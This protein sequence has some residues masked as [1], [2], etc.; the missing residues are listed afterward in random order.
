MGNFIARA[1]EHLKQ[2]GL[3]AQR[4][5][6]RQDESI[7]KIK[8]EGA[9]VLQQAQDGGF[10]TAS[11]S[12]L[13]EAIKKL[14]AYQALINDPNGAG[15]ETF[16]AT[17]EQIDGLTAKLN[18]L[19]GVAEK[20]TGTFASADEVMT[21]W[22]EH[23]NAG[24]TASEGM[25]QTLDEKLA[26]ATSSWDARI[27][28]QT[29]YLEDC[30]KSLDEYEQELQELSDKLKVLEQKH[31]NH[32]WLWKKTHARQYQREEENIEWLR[33]ETG[34]GHSFDEEGNIKRTT[35]KGLVDDMRNY[36]QDAQK[37]LALLKQLKAEELGLTESEVQA[38]EKKADAKRLTNEQMQEG[39]KLLEEEYARTEHTTEEGIKKREQL[40]EAIDQMNQELKESTGEWMKLADAEKLAE[41]AGKDTFLNKEGKGFIASP[42]EIQKAT[43][44]LERRRDALIKNMKTSGEATKEQERELADLTKK[45]KDLKFEQDN[46]NM[47][48]EKMQM[49]MRTP[50]NAV[51]LDEL[52]AAIKRADAELKRME[53]S[54]GQN[55]AQYQEF[56]AQVKNTKNMLKEMEGQAKAS[57]TAWEKAWSRLKT[58]VVMYMGF[59]AVWQKMVGTADDIMELSDKMGE[60]RKTTGFTA[61]EV[62][63][64]S[65]N[66]KRLDVRTPLTQLMELSAKA[67]QL[68]LKTEQDV[69]GFTE[70]ANKLMIALPEMGAEA[71]TEM[72]KVAIAT[73]EV[74]KIQ[75]Q[76]NQ[77]LIEGSSA[78]EV[79]LSKVGSTID[80]L[81]AN[82]AAAAPQITDFVKRVGAVGAQSGITIDQIAALGATVD[83]IG[84][85]VEMSATAL[86]RMIPAIKNNAFEV[87]KA[88]GM[89]PNALREMFDEAGGGMEAMLAIF[90][91][92]K[93]AGMD[94]DSIEKML[95]MGGMQDVMKQLNQQGVRAGIVFAGLSQNVDELRKNLGVATEAYEDNI[96][97]LQEYNKMNDTTAAKWERFKNQL[98]EFFVGD[99]TQGVLGAIIDFLRLGLDF[100]T[101]NNGWSAA[102]RTIGV[103]LLAVKLNIASIF[104]G[105]KNISVSLKGIAMTIGLI[106]KE[107]KK[108]AWGNIFTAMA[109]A[110]LWLWR[111]LAKL[112]TAT[113]RANESLGKTKE[114][115][116]QVTERFDG[117]WD[118][119]K[120]TSEALEEAKASH[121][122]LSDAVD[123][124]RKTTDGSAESSAKLK[125]AE[126]ELKNSEN[127]VTRASNAH[128]AA[129]SQMNSIYGKYLGFILTEAN[130]S[131]LAAA[132]HD[133]V[134]AA[135]EREMLMKQK[136]AAIGEVDSSYADKIAEG[137]GDLNE[138]LV[139]YGHLQRSEAAKAMSDMQ[140][141]MRENL[142]YDETKGETVVNEAIIKQLKK[143]HSGLDLSDAEAN[144]IAGLW[145]NDYLKENFKMGES[146]R[147]GL[148]G[149][150]FSKDDTGGWGNVR[151]WGSNLR[152]D[153]AET[154]ADREKGRGATA[155][156]YDT[157]LTAARTKEA[158]NSTE[159]LNKLEKRAND[160]KKKIL[161]KK[162]SD[163]DRNEAY[164]ELANSLEGL[165]NRI[166]ELDPQKDAATIDRLNNL[167]TSLKGQGIDIKKLKQAREKIHQT[168][169]EKATFNEGD[170]QNLDTTNPWGEK[171]GA[172]S[173]DWK[174][175]TA[176]Q[177]VNR[178]K[179]MKD[180]V[181]AIQTDSDV[182]TVLAEDAALKKAIEKG[183]A[184]DMRTVIEWYNTERLK[185]QD[186]LHARY[187]TNTG[188]WMD[189]KKV[190][191]RKKMLHD[192]TRMFLDELDAYYTER[193][194]K[195]Q[196]AG[197]EE[198]ITEAEM[199]NRTLA[200]EAE[201]RQRRMELQKMYGDKAEEVTQ[202]EQNAIFNIIAE[203]TD[204]DVKVIKGLYQKTLD[205]V[206]KVSK[207]GEQGEK[208]AREFR[209]KMDKQAM[210]DLLKEQNA[211][212][213][214]MKAIQDIIDKERPF[215]GITKNLRE[216]LVTMGILTADMTEERNRLMAE[217]ADMAD[218]NAR[219]AAEELKRTAFMLGEAEN[220]Y[221]TTIEDIMKRMADAGMTAWADELKANPK[222]REAL[223]AQLHQ[224]YDDIQEAIKKEASLMKKHAENMWNNILLPGGDG[225]T[226]VK[227]AFEQA[228]SQLGIDQ[229]RV[230]RANSLIGAGAA[231]ERVADR[232]AIKQMKLQLTMQEHYFNLMRKQGQQRID[233]LKRQADELERQGELEKASRVRQDKAHAEMSLRLATTKEQTE[234]LKQQEDI[235]A[236]T[237]E[238]QNRLYKELREWGDLLANS[239]RDLMEASNAGNAEYYNEL[240]KLN[241]TGKGGPGAGTYI[242]IDNEGTSDATAH[243]EYLSE[244][245]ALERQHEIE[246]E[247]ARAEAW[248]KVWD[249]LNAKMNEQITDWMNAALQNESIDA[250][251]NAVNANTAALN[252]LTW[253]VQSDTIDKATRRDDNIPNT[254]IE[255][256]GYE[257]TSPSESTS[258]IENGS[259]IPFTEDGLAQRQ[260]MAWAY[261]ETV[262]STNEQII[263][264]TNKV[265]EAFNRQFHSQAEGTKTTN[266]LMQQSTQSTFAKMT[267]AANLY[268]IAYQTM[269]NDNLDAS[270]K[271]ELFALQAAG[272]AAIGMLTTNLFKQEADQ[273]VKMPG[274]LGELLGQMPYPVAMATYAAVTAL[275]GGLM[276]MA[277]SKVA[278]SKSQIAQVTGAS[279]SAGRLATG[280]LTYAEGN[281]NEF[282]DPGSLTPGKQYNVDGRDGKTYRA[283]YMGEGAKTHIT[284]GP[285]FHL[286]GEKGREAIID[287]HTTR[288]IQLNE[289][290][291]WGAIKTLYNGGSL[292]HSTRRRGVRAFADGNLDEFE[293]ADGGSM[294]A[295]GMDLAAVKDS[296]DRNSAVQE[297]LLERLNEPI[298]AQNILYGPEGLPA[299]LKK[300]QKEAERHG[301]KYL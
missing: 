235:I 250:N 102:F 82:S 279:A 223:I 273:M 20:S 122:K 106:D 233:D 180:F 251:T 190:K 173:T 168:L 23:M 241:L 59:N 147:I 237:E 206:E 256:I 296:L 210:Q 269:S 201:W 11:I 34:S 204:D 143:S 15:A 253:A 32:S 18:A 3:E 115:I 227:D 71:A 107:T 48:Q 165:E 274:I 60:V 36:K 225:K 40:R 230:S 113:D 4:N 156:V 62:G 216:N 292:R 35:T 132:A 262:I 10:A 184:S 167:A 17:K 222:M 255:K 178:R 221:T 29:S 208:E 248:K 260:E 105:V 75:D 257:T 76:L 217:G 116:E 177:L 290:E 13:D 215:N 212:H 119:L 103:Y 169:F 188:D 24:K 163:K 291:I 131:D 185:I 88:I 28:E 265:Q 137:Y 126:D 259:P 277:V 203:R 125:I 151:T 240:A 192:E 171:L 127:G 25:A 98:E 45:I 146:L 64:L 16:A 170:F 47:S 43:Q 129:I 187:L 37:N 287:A 224:T 144:E 44:A 301:E 41:Q 247:N 9:E 193:K 5:A 271:F 97:I 22:A 207:M 252:N 267:A 133:K 179:Q 258:P 198:G 63:R 226:T 238:S 148:S 278:K 232:L 191:A 268:G 92:I 95:G 272:N 73:G 87:A 231:S 118:K 49:L 120:S 83:A 243:Y 175:M 90:Q 281:V 263:E 33:E 246:Q 189:P 202:K 80:Q 26:G 42:E 152:G 196:E 50:T 242:V 289:P 294:M 128:K 58:Y 150:R 93:D 197:I 214:Q 79:A 159:L 239:M 101:G 69:M 89:A 81:R 7:K 67:G 194:A 6:I 27:A 234:L 288:N 53:G 280:V 117:Y 254:T 229:G 111:E 54:L 1:E 66:L 114:D 153:Y 51:S 284:N 219:Q 195:I 264:S 154:Y 266:K 297:A 183:M 285:E 138:R 213:Q 200:N 68:G 299:I 140:K 65:D 108:L 172:D 141:F 19:K 157:D 155:L 186:E 52:R 286:V 139:K 84:L 2:Y 91:H 158:K 295:E 211:M 31:S 161:N 145:F 85:R 110:A 220:A 244:R 249:D 134:T 282:T 30:N 94:A 270:Q 56:A 181:N 164:G 100:L 78:T 121:K 39:I 99:F 130:Y 283:R 300:L 104:S 70:A 298:V 182:K 55:N 112:K 236:R 21:R 228:I 12:A 209:A 96:A 275:M 293:M 61:D 276:G 46:L 149:V 142:K 199:K 135:I 14:K 123:V 72:M 77:G 86:S 176:E 124:L 174:N 160:A 74:K 57:A 136:Q 38:E 162:T 8:D 261:G 109:M 245:E 166:D 205:F 218:F